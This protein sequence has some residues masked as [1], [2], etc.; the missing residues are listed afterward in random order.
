[1]MNSEQK[2]RKFF[3]DYTQRFNNSLA[4]GARVDAKAMRNSFAD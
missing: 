4:D 2:I 3:D 1:M